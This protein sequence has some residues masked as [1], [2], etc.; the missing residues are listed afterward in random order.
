MWEREESQPE[1]IKSAWGAS[2]KRMLNLGDIA[3]NLVQVMSALKRW[4]REKFGSVNKE[5]AMI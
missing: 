3:A 2:G 1:E 4:S 5:I